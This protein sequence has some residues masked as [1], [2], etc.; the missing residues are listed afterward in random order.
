MKKLIFLIV[1]VASSAVFA[2]G[3]AHRTEVKAMPGNIDGPETEGIKARVDIELYPKLGRQ[4]FLKAPS[5]S[6]VSTIGRCATKPRQWIVLETK[7]TT[8]AKCLDQLTFT[9]H[10]VLDTSKALN[11]DKE[12][13]SKLSPYSYFTTSTTYAN[14]PRGSHAASV[15]L[16]PSYAERYGEPVAVGIVVSNQNGDILAGDTI[17]TGPQAGVFKGKEKGYKFWEDDKV[18]NAP[19][20]GDLLYVERRQGLQDRSKTIWAQVNPDDYELVVQ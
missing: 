18:M 3:G 15:C 16:H 14:I 7:Y 5:I 11:K 13:A 1:V 17:A 10:V 4:T 8:Y 20:K 9:W 6:D 2:A 12:D 19:Y